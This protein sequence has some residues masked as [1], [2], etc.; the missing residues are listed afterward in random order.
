MTKTERINT[1]TGSK[2]N[3]NGIA[4]DNLTL[5]WNIT[6]V[7]NDS[8]ITLSNIGNLLGDTELFDGTIDDI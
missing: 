7:S 2:I 3:V 5:S 8:I 1:K 6:K 4:K